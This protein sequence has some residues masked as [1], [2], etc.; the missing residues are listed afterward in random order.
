MR[1]L[2]IASVRTAMQTFATLIVVWLTSINIGMDVD[3]LSAVLA[4]L[5]VGVVTLILRWL[6]TRFP[7][8]TPILSLGVTKTGPSYGA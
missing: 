2:L 5:G 1:Q 7:W 4:A 3:A 6:E 8:L